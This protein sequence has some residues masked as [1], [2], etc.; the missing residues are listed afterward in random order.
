[1]LARRLGLDDEVVLALEHAYER[2]DG[3][4]D[5]AGLEGEEIPLE[6]RIADRRPRC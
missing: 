4:G 2:W 5:P 3:T 6:T 1:M